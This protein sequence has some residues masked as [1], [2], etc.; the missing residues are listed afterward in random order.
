MFLLASQGV[1]PRKTALVATLPSRVSKSCLFL[2]PLFSL[3]SLSQDCGV[4][5]ETTALLFSWFEPKSQFLRF[6]FGWA[7]RVIWL[8]EFDLYGVTL[9][10][11]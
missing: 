8:F 1:A 7:Y 2:P 4:S 11:A 6:W 5:L 9:S 10:Y 3:L